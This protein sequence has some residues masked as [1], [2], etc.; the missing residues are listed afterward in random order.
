MIAGRGPAPRGNSLWITS[1]RYPGSGNFAAMAITPVELARAHAL[2]DELCGPPDEAAD[3][4]VVVLN[5]QAAALAWVRDVTGVYPAPASVS[6]RLDE[7]AASLR[8]GADARDPASA[9]VQVAQEALARHRG[10]P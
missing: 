5:A 8:T 9:L 7:A 10:A 1:L 2:I 3:R 4:V 6:A